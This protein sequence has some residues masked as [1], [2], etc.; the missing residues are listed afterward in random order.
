MTQRAAIPCPECDREKYF[1]GLCY[2]CKNRKLR[3]HYESMSRG[4]ILETVENIIAKIETIDKWEEVYKDFSGLLAYQDIDTSKIADAAFQKKIFYPPTLYRNASDEIQDQLI[5]LICT[6]DCANA[7]HILSCLAVVGGEKV[8][9]TFYELEKNPLPWRKNLYVDTSFYAAL[10]GW[11][12]DQAGN[13]VQLNYETCYSLLEG[14][15]HEDDTVKVAVPKNEN[16]Q[17]CNCQ[18]VDIL[19][20]NGN[21]ERLSFLGL[22]GLLKIPICPNC[23][24][25]CEKTIVRYQIDGAS[26][27][28]IVEPYTEENYL[29]S[30]DFKELTTNKLA[31]SISKKPVYFAYGND[32][33]SI[34]GGNAEWVQDWQ[35]ENCPDCQKKMKLLAALS[36]DQIMNG[37]EGTLY[38]EICTDCSLVVTFHQQT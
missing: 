22:P 30:A 11:T 6:P 19:T 5:A 37:S 38:V 27:F 31:L 14:E 32:D 24:S 20:L 12:F 9:K 10:G 2:S 1:E 7:G 18:T 28:E 3:E 29:S 13:K 21:D 23:A 26:T 4:Q 25:M 35:Y 16:C 36:W 33:V 8:R 15:Q 17:I 34:I